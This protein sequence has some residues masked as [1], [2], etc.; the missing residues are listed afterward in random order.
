MNS[1]PTNEAELLERLNAGD[2]RTVRFLYCDP[3]GVIRGKSVHAGRM[4]GKL[5]EGIGLTRAQNAVNLLEDL[6]NIPGMEPIGEIRLLP[7]LSTYS[8][9]PW[10]PRSA[11]MLV[12]QVDQDMTDW[13][14]CR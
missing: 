7:D 6:V 8:E 5:T 14:C 10:L 4:A 12:D 3:S 13:G 9:L 11:A 1:P 2:I